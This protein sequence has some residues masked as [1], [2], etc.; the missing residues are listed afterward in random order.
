MAHLSEM[1]KIEILI[2]IACGD[3]TRSQME[4]CTMFNAKYADIS[5]IKSHFK[6]LFMR[7]KV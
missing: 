7:Q 6:Y 5:L 1:Q 2:M 3:K 4:V